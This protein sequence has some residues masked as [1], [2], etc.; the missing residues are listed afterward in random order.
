MRIDADTEI[1]FTDDGIFID[2]KNPSKGSYDQVLI[3]MT[4]QDFVNLINPDPNHDA[5]RQYGQHP[6]A[7]DK[8]LGHP[9]RTCTCGLEDALASPLVIKTFHVPSGRGPMLRREDADNWIAEHPAYT[10]HSYSERFL[11]DGS[12]IVTVT[13][14]P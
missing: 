4:R 6:Y 12:V 14:L 1:E 9:D 11:P 10:L 5:L 8:G 13:M 3:P 2:G 7:C